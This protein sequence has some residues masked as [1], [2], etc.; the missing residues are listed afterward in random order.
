MW[1]YVFECLSLYIITYKITSLVTALIEQD[2]FLYLS[3]FMDKCFSGNVFKFLMFFYLLTFNKQVLNLAEVNHTCSVLWLAVLCWCH[4]FMCT[5]SINSGSSRVDRKLMIHFMVLTTPDWSGFVLSTQ[6]LSYNSE[7]VHLPSWYR[8]PVVLFVTWVF[9]YIVK[10][11]HFSRYAKMY[12]ILLV[13]N[14]NLKILNPYP[15]NYTQM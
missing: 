13:R 2:H 11:L 4:T 12:N 8:P 14:A 1:I 7:F 15:V 9:L 3:S 6:N 10:Y 5:H